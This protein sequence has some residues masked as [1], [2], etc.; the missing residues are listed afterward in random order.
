[1]ILQ[2]QEFGLW[3]VKVL[4]LEWGHLGAGQVKAIQLGFYSSH[5]NNRVIFDQS[6]TMK[7]FFQKREI[8]PKERRQSFY[9]ML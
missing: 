7:S 8:I 4:R 3:K 9:M 1:M 5:K 2:M 6:A